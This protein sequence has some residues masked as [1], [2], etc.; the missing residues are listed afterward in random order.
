M[1]FN[2]EFKG[3]INAKSI[4]DNTAKVTL[5]KSVVVTCSEISN[6]TQNI[7]RKASYVHCLSGPCCPIR[8]LSFVVCTEAAGYLQCRPE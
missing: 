2:S 5:I 8:D 4:N 7:R 3:L 6:Q 1:E